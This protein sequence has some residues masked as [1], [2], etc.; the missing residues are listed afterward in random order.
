LKLNKIKTFIIVAG[1][2]LSSVASAGLITLNFDEEVIKNNKKLDSTSYFEDFGIGFRNKTRYVKDNDLLEDGMGLINFRNGRITA[3]W[4]DGVSDLSFDWILNK[5]RVRVFTYDID[6]NLLGKFKLFASDE[7]GTS[8][9]NY[10]NIGK[11]VFKGERDQFLIDSV[12][13]DKK[14]TSVPEPTTLAAFGL[15][16]LMLR[17]RKT[18]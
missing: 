10:N 4:E 11:I 9:V 1:I 18:K 13:W 7:K 5:G 17:L 14:A 6:N 16:L 3:I 2:L 8:F 12:S 15:G